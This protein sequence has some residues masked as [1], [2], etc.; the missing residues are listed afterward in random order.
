MMTGLSAMALIG[1]SGFAVDY[2]NMSRVRSE[3]QNALDTAALAVA[4]KGK[5]IS[6]SEANSVAYNYL[7]GNFPRDFD[8]LQVE[9]DG[10]SVHVTAKVDVDLMFGGIFGKDSMPVNAGSKADVALVSYEIALV[11]DTTGSMQGSKLR[12]MKKAVEEMIDNI[13]AQVDN[14]DR[15]RFALVPFSTFVNVGPQYGPE[16]DEKGKI[17]EGTGAQWLDLYGISEI[18]Q[19]ELKTGVSRFEAFNNLGYE[20]KGC[21]ETRMA[22]GDKRHDV[23]DTQADQRD[24]A[25]LFV[26]AF[27]IDEPSGYQYRNNY[28]NATFNPW[29]N[30]ALAKLE[31]LKKYGFDLLGDIL[32]LFNL[33]RTGTG[34]GPNDMCDAEPL[35]PLTND[36]STLKSKVKQF[37][38]KGNTN[39]MEGVAWGAR[40][41]SPEEPFAGGNSEDGLNKVMV[42]LT[43]GANTFGVRNNGLR[44]YYSS[45]GYM[46]D[47]RLDGEVNAS[48][49][50]S[51]RLM[52]EKTIEACDFAKESGIDIYTIRLEVRDTDTGDMMRSCASRPDQYFDTPSSRQ[53]KEVFEKIGEQIVKLRLSS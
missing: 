43:D 42:V 36:Y 29:D 25:S 9:R 28:L 5:K 27:A 12:D 20:W 45:F 52:N 51:T 10:R 50:K 23:A 22:D 19:L 53:L 15:L 33:N 40:V 1:A 41:L 47:G 44:S 8:A 24:P 21:V 35:T 30:H 49:S 7:K 4:Q 13:S 2:A 39:I 6:D 34:Y 11:L 48:T 37:E 26:P 31:K 46:I 38:A 18:P 32:G 17:K 3:L 14:K 16:F